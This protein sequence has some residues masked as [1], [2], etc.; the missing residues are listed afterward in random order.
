M[1]ILS[2]GYLD[3]L[4][5]NL[6]PRS[7]IRPLRIPMFSTN[8]G[9]ILLSTS[10]LGPEYWVA[11]LV[12]PVLFDTAIKQA[13][14]Y[15]PNVV[16]IELGPHSTLESPLKQICAEVKSPVNYVSTMSR[17]R[18]SV[19][20]LLS[21]IGHLYQQGIEA[22]MLQLTDQGTILAD[23]PRY[24]WHN[25]SF[26]K[27]SRMIKDWKC[28]VRNRHP[29]VGQ[30]IS[31]STDLDP[32][33]RVML[34]VDS[35]PWLRGHR[36]KDNIVFPLAG[37]IVMAVECL[38]QVSKSNSGYELRHIVSHTTMILPETEAT[39]IIIN[40]KR[41]RL[42][43]KSLS[44][45]YEFSI[46]SYCNSVWTNHCH[47]EVKV[48]KATPIAKQLPQ[49][50][51]LEVPGTRLY[52]YF[53]TAGIYFGEEF[54]RLSNVS[55]SKSKCEATAKIMV[56]DIH[57]ATEYIT[58]PCTLDACF[59][60]ILFASTK[61]LTKHG[62]LYIPTL[63]EEMYIS[64]TGGNLNTYAWATEGREG[65]YPNGTDCMF[66]GKL[67]IHVAN[68]HVRKIQESSIPQNIDTHAAAHMEWL[69][70]FDFVEDKLHVPPQKC[71]DHDILLEELV[72]LCMIDSTE[73]SQE[74]S[75]EIP[76]LKKY[77]AWLQ[78]QVKLS[79]TGRHKL[80]SDCSSL[81]KLDRMERDAAIHKRFLYLQVAP[82]QLAMATGVMKIREHTTGILKGEEDALQLLMENS[83]LN[84]IYSTSRF[85]CKQIVQGL[86]NKKPTL[87]ILEVGAGTG[88]ATVQVLD[89]LNSNNPKYI[90]GNSI[91]TFTDISSGFF[92]Q[93]KARFSDIP[94]LDYRI[95]DISKN[96]LDQGFLANSYDLIIAANCIHA[97]PSLKNTLRN[98]HSLLRSDGRLLFSEILTSTTSPGFVFGNFSGW[99]LGEEEYRQ[100]Q[101]FISLQRWES[102]LKEAG[103][104]GI[105]SFAPDIEEPYQ[106]SGLIS[107]VPELEDIDLPQPIVVLC[108]KPKVGVSQCLITYL[109]SVC[110][111]VSV[112]TLGQ[113]IPK[114]QHVISTLDLETPTFDNI[115]ETDLEDFKRTFNEM[116]ALKILWLMPPVQIRCKDPS[117]AISLGILRTMRIE[118]GLPLVTLEISQTE[119]AFENLVHRLFQ[120]V[121]STQ[122]S[123]QLLPDTEFVVDKGIVKISRFKPF[124][125]IEERAK[126]RAVSTGGPISLTIEEV[127]LLESLKFV[128]L[129]QPPPIGDH[130]V[131]VIT[132]AVGLNFHVSHF[133]KCM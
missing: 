47:G 104:N 42:T 69:P 51:E 15:F 34:S 20:T 27:E 124:S 122:A 19:E 30:L 120:R 9:T 80:L 126:A 116:E 33:W 101:P 105:E 48:A 95:L 3:A 21:A 130:E 58:H 94:N 127:G 65:I 108:R 46:S 36:I 102:E 111:K 41:L 125:L 60:L 37:Y 7:S 98:L 61:S 49:F 66:D 115:S 113:I 72:L 97:T 6:T 40:L 82:P 84:N 77:Q 45:W 121:V 74:Y 129:D 99:W 24:P 18:S 112:S 31:Q 43:D 76:H 123:D 96:P 131:E 71:S 118:L 85:P 17:H 10:E 132:R 4:R 110:S 52:D 25:N 54:Q 2:A 29:F 64:N 93:A 44:E 114:T 50:L 89:A 91:Y 109:Q 14:E 13:L 16:F 75:T 67:A 68:M 70:D 59:Q 38:C 22:D 78:N 83:I 39:E 79:H 55:S 117:A 62:D 56:P 88:G 87:R 53:A 119:P 100:Q 90:P 23:L 81:L 63:I 92:E 106:V 35:M 86:S 1:E 107:A 11:N 133:F 73:I 26:W 57:S 128:E 28:A 12:S 32:S 103:F 8:L 5:R